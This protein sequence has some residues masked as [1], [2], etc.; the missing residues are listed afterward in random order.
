M[1]R[2][3]RIIGAIATSMCEDQGAKAK[4]SDLGLCHSGYSMNLE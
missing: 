4:E 3:D 2:T 1:R